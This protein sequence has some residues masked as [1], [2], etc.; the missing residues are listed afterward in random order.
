MPV[1]A[2]MTG[3]GGVSVTA[4]VPDH[5]PP[6]TPILIAPPDGSVLAD[7]TPTFQWYE[8]TDDVAMYHYRFYLNGQLL[9]NY[10]PLNNFENSDYSLTYDSLNGIYSLTPKKPFDDRSYS[11][12]IRALDY[13]DNYSN[14]VSWTFT[15]DTLAP[16][17]IVRQIADVRTSISAQNPSSVPDTPVLLF[18][19]DPLANEPIIVAVGEARSRVQLRVTIPNQPELNYEST[20]DDNGN[21]Q[22]QLAI[23]PRNV[24]IR[25]DFI[26]TDLAGHVS[27]LEGLYIRINTHY[28]PGTPIPTTLTPPPGM[29]GGPISPTL[30]PSTTP[31]PSVS[32]TTK[33]SSLTPHPSVSPTPLPTRKPPLGDIQVPII[34]P[35]EIAHEITRE[36]LKFLPMTLRERISE[37]T[38]S[39]AWLMLTNFIALLY[40]LL[41]PLLS[42]TLI[43][44][45]YWELL[46]PKLLLEAGR[47]LFLLPFG[48]GRKKNLV[49]DY[50]S[51][52]AAP[53][54][55]VELNDVASGTVLDYRLTD[56]RGN[57]ADFSW[58]QQR[59]LKMWVNDAN[60]YYPVG[61]KKP[62]QLTMEQFYQDESFQ[63]PEQAAPLWLL[64]T[65]APRGPAALPL[66]EK[67]RI[68]CLYLSSYPWWFYAFLLLPVVIL[69]MR[70]YGTVNFIALG[71]VLS[72][73][74]SKLVQRFRETSL[75]TLQLQ[76]YGKN[77]QR[78]QGQIIVSCCS[79]DKSY[80]QAF[81]LP[82]SF[83][84]AKKLRLPTGQY[85]MTIFAKDR[86]PVW[87]NRVVGSQLLELRQKQ[88]QLEIT[89]DYFP[90]NQ[91]T[92]TKLT[93]IC[94]L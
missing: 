4:A 85:Q 84:A 93:P 75:A 10:I 45:K 87:D 61:V 63:L 54:V 92:L 77:G 51:G 6:S 86:A 57:F 16:A 59:Q 26:I 32:P 89:L 36:T 9:F 30:R 43:I 22:Q 13:G 69:T 55:K 60:F 90:T 65:L 23:L 34:P 71:L 2:Q 48:R 70:Y 76:L 31:K 15:I 52:Q 66:L 80:Q 58:P 29:G 17:F 50:N 62:V 40:V 19:R 82:V 53:L 21:Y 64:P 46:S 47:L 41:L 56:Q 73:G 88:Q 18:T 14:S 39:R 5:T 8:S 24:D 67:L 25:L 83:A 7:N 68:T 91:N 81:A 42:F 78:Y 27:V 74:I 1:Q 38:S 33:P 35:R 94:Q 72:L 3:S 11:W 12:Y 44:S 37:L 28:W 20:I 49:F 79:L